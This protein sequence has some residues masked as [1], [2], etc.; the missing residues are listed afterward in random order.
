M[1]PPR[2]TV[3]IVDDERTLLLT[4]ENSLTSYAPDLEILTAENG[5]QAVD[6]LGTGHVDLVVTDLKMPEMDGFQ[7]LIHMKKNYPD[8]PVIVMTAIG[9]PEV[10]DR[11]RSLG[12]VSYLEKPVNLKDLAL[13]IFQGIAVASEGRISGVTLAGFLELVVLE[14]KTCALKVISGDRSGILLIKDGDLVDART[15]D[16]IGEAAARDIVT[17]DD[18]EIK[19]GNYTG[20]RRKNVDATLGDILLDAFRSRDER[21]QAA[22]AP[23]GP[24]APGDAVDSGPRESE[25]AANAGPS[26]PAQAA[27]EAPAAAG[28]SPAAPAG[29]T[30][31]AAAPDGATATAAAPA[32]A[33]ASPAAPAGAGK[34]S[35]APSAADRRNNVV[36]FNKEK[37]MT[38]LRDL[39]SEL[40][41]MPGVNAV[42]L[43]GC[44]G[45]LID[46]IANTET[47]AELV[48]AIAS[49][50]LGAFESIARELG[51]GAL[52]LT[53]HEFE[54]GPVIISPV[55][56]EFVL[57]IVAGK[58]ASLGMLRLKMKKL[59]SEIEA[60]AEVV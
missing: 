48:G 39:L 22:R 25:D 4:F 56:K 59:G 60:A 52:E 9:F 10:A 17:W 7:L 27:G 13:K 14:R 11:L 24:A 55:G 19:M 32:G 6:L 49:S 38:R 21:K 47:D 15:D 51:R 43:A 16:L 28:T 8:T 40:S 1:N 37:S 12:T 30:A 46:S 53:M 3:L 35:V 36:P 57:V 26:G 2:K 45:L 42:C 44:D 5:L 29:A 23:G 58:D 20:D 54:Q 50:G 34:S 31:T 41:A 18:A 33:S